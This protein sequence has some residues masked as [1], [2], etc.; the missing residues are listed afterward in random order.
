MNELFIVRDYDN[1]KRILGVYLTDDSK[2]C[3]KIFS[4]LDTRYCGSNN[5]DDLHPLES[6][7]FEKMCKEQG[8]KVELI[9]TMT[10]YDF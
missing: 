2:K 3:E 1:P 6:G 8:V 10:Q 5:D 4:D 7:I 9:D